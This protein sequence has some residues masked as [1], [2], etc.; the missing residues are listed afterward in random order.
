[1]RSVTFQPGEAI[2]RQGDASDCVYF[3]EAGAVEVRVGIGEGADEA[4]LAV[5]NR[6]EILGEMGVIRSCPRSTT[7]VAVEET[8]LARID[9]PDFLAA[10]GGPDGIGL[11]LLRMIC[12]RLSETSSGFGAAKTS[13]AAL[14]Q[15]IS[16]IRLLGDS[17]EMQAML[18]A[19]GI[20][21]PKLPFEVGSGSTDAV[22][23]SPERLSLPVKSK[24]S[25]LAERHF[26]LEIGPKGGLYLRDLAS[27]LGCVVNGR[28]ISTF[29]RFEDGGLAPLMLGDN[30]IVAGGVYSPVCFKLRLRTQAQLAA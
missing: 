19:V 23:T 18:G 15:D 9:G 4:V 17:P 13:T 27:Q 26:R 28:R 8:R 5:L 11:K 21:I 12:A 29:E 14:R 25:P 20:V 3:I 1:M 30:T 7:L 6:G 2:Y 16:E 10:F 24:A 22:V